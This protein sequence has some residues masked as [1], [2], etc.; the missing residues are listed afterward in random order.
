M[1]ITS[2][3][4]KSEYQIHVSFLGHFGIVSLLGSIL[5]WFFMAGFFSPK[6][7]IDIIM[8]NNFVNV[9]IALS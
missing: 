3:F 9:V 6:F 2:V 1:K 4:R 5:I 7:L 8:M